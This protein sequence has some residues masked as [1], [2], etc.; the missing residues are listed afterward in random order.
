MKNQKGFIL[1]IIIIISLLILAVVA[2]FFSPNT[3]NIKL[4]DTSSVTTADSTTNWKTYQD[5][6]YNF[7]FAYPN[8]WTVG[9]SKVGG[10]LV[11][12]N[13]ENTKKEVL[14]APKTIYDNGG[15]IGKIYI[16]L[17]DVDSLIENIQKQM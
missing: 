13:F 12:A 10:E 11:T 9:L 3:I 1:P 7:S 6:D 15:H 8:N 4:P 14:I 16:G 17:I 5:P 2:Y